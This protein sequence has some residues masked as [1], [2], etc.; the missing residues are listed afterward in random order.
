MRAQRAHTPSRQY[1]RRGQDVAMPSSSASN[2]MIED[3]RDR[4]HR[5]AARCTPYGAR[6]VIDPATRT[7]L[8]PHPAALAQAAAVRG[9]SDFRGRFRSMM[10]TGTARVQRCSKKST[11]QP[12]TILIARCGSFY[13]EKDGASC[14]GMLRRKEIFRRMGKNDHFATES[15]RDALAAMIRERQQVERSAPGCAADLRRNG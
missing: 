14:S 6:W 5:H 2:R 9:V 11:S 1:L 15:Q 3:R 4:D 7:H 12:R 13:F 10:R 8:T